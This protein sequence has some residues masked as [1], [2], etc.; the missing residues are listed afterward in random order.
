MS[1]HRPSHITE[2]LGNWYK[3]ETLLSERRTKDAI[4]GDVSVAQ[5]YDNINCIPSEKLNNS[6]AFFTKG[7]FTIGR[8]KLTDNQF[9]PEVKKRMDLSFTNP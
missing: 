3:R 2:Y 7:S 9:P 5:K 1:F 4:F 8:K 6:S